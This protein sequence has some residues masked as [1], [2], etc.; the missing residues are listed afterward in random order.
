MQAALGRDPVKMMIENIK[1]LADMQDQ[2][3]TE[4]EKLEIL[5]NLCDFCE[6]IDLASGLKSSQAAKFSI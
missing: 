6:D 2:V 5:D 3:V 4:E 1:A